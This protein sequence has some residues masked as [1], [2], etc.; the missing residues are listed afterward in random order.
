MTPSALDATLRRRRVAVLAAGVAL[1][2][3][4][5]GGGLAWWLTRSGGAGA[6][7]S[8]QQPA[9]RTYLDLSRDHVEG[10]VAY[11]QDPPVGGAH[12]PAWAN[13]G[14]YS[15]PIPNELGVHSLEHGAFWITYRPDLPPDQLALLERDVDGRPY[16]LLSPY[17]DLPSPVVITAWG[18]QLR[19]DSADDPALADF[20][21]DY[22]DGSKA[23]EPGAACTG[24]VGEPDD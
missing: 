11:P 3:A 17:P 10:E 23:P 2:L 18:V 6:A 15:D 14:V 7:P 12:W 13:C 4:A 20:I 8:A 24:G 21:D 19:V 22:G 16:G 5:G 9:R 1:V